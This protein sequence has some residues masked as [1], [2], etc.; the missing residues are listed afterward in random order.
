MKFYANLYSVTTFYTNL[1]KIMLSQNFYAF[2]FYAVWEAWI[3]KM[4]QCYNLILWCTASQCSSS[5]VEVI[6]LFY[7]SH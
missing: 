7:S 4:G 1:T 5:N 2:Y 6:I 3:H